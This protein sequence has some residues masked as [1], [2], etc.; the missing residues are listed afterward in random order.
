MGQE[1]KKIKCSSVSRRRKHKTSPDYPSEGRTVPR[2]RVRDMTAELCGE[3]KGASWAG[4][5]LKL[6]C[7]GRAGW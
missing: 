4:Y 1:K 3:V 7:T 5:S 6:P 2:L